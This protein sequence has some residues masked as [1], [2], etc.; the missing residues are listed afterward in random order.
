MKK[1]PMT[2]EQFQEIF[3]EIVGSPHNGPVESHMWNMYMENINTDS[4]VKEAK[5]FCKNLVE[6][7][8]EDN[9]GWRDEEE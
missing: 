8:D 9:P 7:E 2:N 6:L 3:Y 4:T 5:A 1:V